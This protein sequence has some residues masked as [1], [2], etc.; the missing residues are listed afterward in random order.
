LRLSKPQDFPDEIYLDRIRPL[1]EDLKGK[2]DALWDM[3]KGLG[4]IAAQSVIGAGV[5]RN[6][7]KFGPFRAPNVGGEICVRCGLFCPSVQCGDEI[8][9]RTK[10]CQT[11][12]RIPP[13]LSGNLLRE[14]LNLRKCQEP[15]KCKV[16]DASWKKTDAV[17][18]E[19]HDT[20]DQDK[21]KPEDNS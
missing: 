20:K 17:A 2:N 10:W 12:T 18:G 19:N 5:S 8:C 7:G 21:A 4:I 6:Q 11:C 3:A 14:C 1:P 9:E 15:Q 16:L 13:H